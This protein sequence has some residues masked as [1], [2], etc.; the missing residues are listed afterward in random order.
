[1]R[2]YHDRYIRSP[3]HFRN[4]VRYIHDNPVKARLVAEPEQW[5]WS[6][7]HAYDESAWPLE[8]DG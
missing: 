5:R 4:V 8:A 3:R 6:G 7:I 2:D 1:M